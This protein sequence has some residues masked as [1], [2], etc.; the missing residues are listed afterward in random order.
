M[1]YSHLPTEKKSTEPDPVIGI[2]HLN[3][4]ASTRLPLPIPR[5]H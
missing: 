3:P 2:A 1:I 4:A 5:H